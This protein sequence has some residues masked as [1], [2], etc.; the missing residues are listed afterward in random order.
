MTIK[1]DTVMN[2]TDE[3]RARTVHVNA[4][5]KDYM[6]RAEGFQKTVI[7]AVNYSMEGSG[8][9]LRPMMMECTYQMYGGRGPMIGPF[10]A[11]MEMIHNSSLIHDDLPALDNDALRR[12]RKTTHI[13]YGEPLAI[14]AGD[15]LLNYAYET[16]VRA[17]E[18][19]PRTED[20]AQGYA[21]VAQALWVL[22][23]KS[24]INGMLGG[25]SCDVE[26]EGQALTET[27]VE[28]INKNKTG[29]LIEG[30]L[31]IGAI[32]AGAGSDQVQKLESIGSDIGLAFQIRDDILDV[33]GNAQEIG[34]PIGSD[35]RNKK[36]TYISLFGVQAGR[37]RVEQLSERALETFD[38][39]D[40]EHGFLRQLLEELA[41]RRR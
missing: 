31:M 15:V 22:A 11:A 27:Q 38:S 30:S 4:V 35:V 20:P 2:Y 28:F 17:F 6:P 3:L 16:A 23:T 19:V 5:L 36:T 41:T 9:R 1:Q 26:Y 24:G 14:M 21:R 40:A 37:Q 32:L 33:T 8:K 39:L 10:M 18:Q 25:Q 13:E 7:E 12:G 29:A 34:K